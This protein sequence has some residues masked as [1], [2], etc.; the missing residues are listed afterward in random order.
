[1]K[2]ALGKNWLEV[3]KLFI[4]SDELWFMATVPGRITYTFFRG[5]SESETFD[6]VSFLFFAPRG[7][8]VG[9]KEEI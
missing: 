9:W 1:M 3:G 8:R 5:D 2:L 7:L 4:L 6:E